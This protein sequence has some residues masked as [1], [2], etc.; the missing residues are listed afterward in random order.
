MVEKHGDASIT[1]AELIARAKEGEQEAF[2]LLYRRYHARIYSYIRS[3][4]DTVHDA[5]D[6]TERVFLKSFEAMRH[7]QDRGL[8]YSVYLY[9]VARHAVIDYYRGKDTSHPLDVLDQNAGQ[10]RSVENDVREREVLQEIR[11]ALEQLPEPYQEIIRLR[12]LLGMTAEE[13][14]AWMNKT[15]GNIRVLLHRALKALRK[16]LGS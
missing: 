7:Y 12:I 6:L 13:A 10:E 2:G 8:P 15:P 11:V 9:Q 4:V 5:E 16:K 3:R 1:D 14:G